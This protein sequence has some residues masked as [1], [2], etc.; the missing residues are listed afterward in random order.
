M[1]ID[2]RQTA[3]N[4]IDIWLMTGGSNPTFSADVTFDFNISLT[5]A[6]TNSGSGTLIAGQSEVFVANYDPTLESISAI[7]VNNFDPP[8]I[9]GYNI[10][11]IG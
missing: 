1:V 11:P 10:N 8:T 3:P 2:E 9:D 4:N 7:T 5:P 6:G